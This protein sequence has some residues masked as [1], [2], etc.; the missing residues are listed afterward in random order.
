MGA[1]PIRASNQGRMW[2]PKVE[3]SREIF[4]SD[5][6]EVVHGNRSSTL[7]VAL[8]DHDKSLLIFIYFIYLCIYFKVSLLGVDSLWGECTFILA[9]WGSL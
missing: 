1:N 7:C 3:G 8:W 9:D 6:F 4:K 2:T 5:H